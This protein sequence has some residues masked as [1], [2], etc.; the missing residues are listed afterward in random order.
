MLRT[1][2]DCRFDVQTGTVCRLKAVNGLSWEGL[3]CYA[4]VGVSGLRVL[5]HGI[6]YKVRLKKL[7]VFGGM[8]CDGAVGSGLSI[9]RTS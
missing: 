9:F 8:V 4:L 2:M 6:L 7:T 5:T 1:G 3:W